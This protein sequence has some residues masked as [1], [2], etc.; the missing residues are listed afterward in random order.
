MRAVAFSLG[1]NVVTDDR[2]GQI[3]DQEDRRCQSLIAGDFVG[4]REMLA[5]DLVHIHGNGLIDAKDAYLH[6]ISTQLEFIDVRRSEVV[7]RFFGDFAIATGPMVQTVRVKA[8]GAV[9]EVRASVTIVWGRG[10]NGWSVH[11]FQATNQASH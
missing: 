2:T 7:V 5:D 1:E 11:S 4:L 10:A 9:I 6:T 3:L 8:S